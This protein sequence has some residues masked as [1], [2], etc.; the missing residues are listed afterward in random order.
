[1]ALTLDPAVAHGVQLKNIEPL[2]FTAAL[3]VLHPVLVWAEQHSTLFRR[4]RLS[5]T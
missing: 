1:M 5:F 4:W 3:L 2:T